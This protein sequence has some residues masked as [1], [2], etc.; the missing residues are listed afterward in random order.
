[1]EF[2]RTR[3]SSLEL[4]QACRESTIAVANC[5]SGPVA[6]L[7]FEEFLA[8]QHRSKPKEQSPIARQPLDEDSNESEQG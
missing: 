5:G 2:M 4:R 6:R 1:M 8:E 3:Q 7:L